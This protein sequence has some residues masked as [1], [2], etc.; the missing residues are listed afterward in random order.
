MDL[1]FRKV[2]C[3]SIEKIGKSCWELHQ[4]QRLYPWYGE[5]VEMLFDPLNGGTMTVRRKPELP[6]L[7]SATMLEF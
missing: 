4:E 2:S 1:Y 5:G 6:A 3:A 7:R